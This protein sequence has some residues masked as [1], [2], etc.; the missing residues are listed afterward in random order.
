MTYETRQCGRMRITPL[1]R[2]GEPIVESSFETDGCWSIGQ[3]HG[4]QLPEERTSWT[5]ALPGSLSLRM[6]SKLAEAA[7][8]LGLIKGN[9]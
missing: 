1:D 2:D 3:E 4:M 8:Q 6:R 5:A 9:S 7:R